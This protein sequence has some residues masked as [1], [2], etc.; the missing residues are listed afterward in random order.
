MCGICGV[1]FRERHPALEAQVPVVASMVRKMQRRGPDDEGIWYDQG[2]CILGFRRLA[3]LDLSSSGHQPMES[4]DKRFALVFNGE[5][6]NFKELR[7]E[8]EEMGIR[9]CST[10]DTEVVLMALATWGRTALKRLNGM[11]AIGF[12]DRLER[13]ILIARDHAGIKPV[14]IL[15]TAQG[16]VFASQY[17]QILC[18]PWSRAQ[19]L[20]RAALALYLQLGYVPSPYGIIYNTGLLEAGTSLEVCWD[21]TSSRERFFA[22]PR[23]QVPELSG[24][25]ACEAV[26]AAVAASVRRQLVSDVPVGTFLSGGIDSPLVTAKAADICGGRIDAFNIGLDGAKEDESEDALNYAREFH[27]NINIEHFRSADVLA[28]L[29][30][31]VRAFGE[32]FADYSAFPTYMACR[33]ARQRVKVMLSGDG[34]DE[35]FWG[36]VGRFGSILDS[37]MAFR[38]SHTARVAR[39]ILSRTFGDGMVAR[40]TMFPTIGHWMRAKH[41]RIFPGQIKKLFPDLGDTP[42][43]YSL[44]DYCGADL[45]LT[46]QWLRWNEFVGHLEMVLLK[47]DRASMFNS[48]EVRVPL[49]DRDVVDVAARIDWR[50]CLDLKRGIGKLPL[51]HSLRKHTQRQTIVKRGF[52]VPMGDWMR[53]PL[54]KVFEE[55]VLDRRAIL[56][57]PFE[58]NVARKMFQEHLSGRIDAGHSLWILLSLG[59]WERIHWSQNRA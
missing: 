35:L 17:D 32:P 14:Y 11:F 37:A 30:D 29:D 28:V 42:A 58:S 44:F 15:E 41:S 8:L 16:I 39:R 53:G 38:R 22:F 52:S 46:A 20:N 5:V 24:E 51:R 40:A 33:S 21:G 36:Y 31:V 9:F 34:G 13:R 4:G 43:D 6:Y 10:G 23:E 25:E 49:L 48:L 45:D 2:H 56:G 12:Y 59:L 27:V 3:I 19:P 1:F 57:V 54:K 18:H 47:V 26:D 7:R 50:S 55:V